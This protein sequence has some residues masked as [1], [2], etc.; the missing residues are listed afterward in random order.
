MCALPL[1]S[2]FLSLSFPFP[3]PLP[4]VL[5]P[6]SGTAPP[7]PSSL[8]PRPLAPGRP[9][10]PW[11]R[12]PPAACARRAPSPLPP[13]VLGHWLVL[14]SFSCPAPDE[15]PLVLPSPSL[16]PSPRLA[17]PMFCMSLSIQAPDVQVRGDVTS[18]LE[19]AA[20]GGFCHFFHLALSL[21]PSF[22]LSP[23]LSPSLFFPRTKKK[24]KK[25]MTAIP[26]FIFPAPSLYYF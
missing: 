1:P 25:A 11:P 22:P 14:L 24:K 9:P 21:L 18:A 8:A 16:L 10:P 3:F 13:A 15:C 23:S 12:G 4:P 20:Q 19:L 2:F 6:G 5:L 7:A 26:Q 17:L